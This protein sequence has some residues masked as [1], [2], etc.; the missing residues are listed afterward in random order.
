VQQ[1]RKNCARI[2]QGNAANPLTINKNHAEKKS[3]KNLRKLIPTNP[4]L[5]K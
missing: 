5:S 4:L 2:V 1:L 3:F